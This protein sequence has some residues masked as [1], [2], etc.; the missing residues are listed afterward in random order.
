MSVVHYHRIKFP[1]MAF[2]HNPR[3]VA[4]I[5]HL[6]FGATA[7]THSQQFIAVPVRRLYRYYVSSVGSI[8]FS[9]SL[10][11]CL[12]FAVPADEVADRLALDFTL[13]LTSV[14]YKLYLSTL[15]PPVS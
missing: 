9:I 13:L 15:T 5:R 10:G 4:G 8:L 11:G 14:A 6:R 3:S 7:P 1:D 2:P 12:V